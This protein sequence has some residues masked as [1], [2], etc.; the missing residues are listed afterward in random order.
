MDPNVIEFF[1]KNKDKLDN[2][3]EFFEAS[4]EFSRRSATFTGK[5]TQMLEECGIDVLHQVNRIYQGMFSYHN[6]HYQNQT[7]ITIPK[8]IITIGTSAFQDC[9]TVKQ[10]I[11][12]PGLTVIGESAFNRCNNLQQIKLP[13]TV[14]KIKSFAFF[15]CYRVKTF[16]FDGTVAQWNETDVEKNWCDTSSIKE[17]IC[18]NGKV[19]LY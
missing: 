6:E 19:E 18:K 17:I 3:D 16:E 9:T 1:Q 12:E 15:G 8:N 10:L 13:S 14:Y 5:I 4:R 11:I 7:S 2:L